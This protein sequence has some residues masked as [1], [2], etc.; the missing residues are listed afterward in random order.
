VA[1]TVV[2]PVERTHR[3]VVRYTSVAGHKHGP[4]RSRRRRFVESRGRSRSV[5]ALGLSC[6]HAPAVRGGWCRKR[7]DRERRAELGIWRVEPAGR[8][9][10][11]CRLSPQVHGPNLFVE[12]AGEWVEIFVSAYG[13]SQLM[14]CSG[15]VW[16]TAV[17]TAA[18]S[19]P[20]F[21]HGAD[22]TVRDSSPRFSLLGAGGLASQTYRVRLP[23]PARVLT[24]I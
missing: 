12:G 14:T 18:G 8:G 1:I 4:S 21:R 9:C 19:D 2:V 24:V 7:G 23:L 13:A 6:A 3:H 5:V 22:A 15:A 20:D 11:L 17:Q 16:E 10:H